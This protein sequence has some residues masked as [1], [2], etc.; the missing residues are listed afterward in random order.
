MLN[1][2]FFYSRV[3]FS[4]DTNQNQTVG[5]IIAG[6][7]SSVAYERLQNI[8][9]GLKAVASRD[10]KSSV[11][12]HIHLKSVLQG[13]V[14][15]A[16]ILPSLK[17]QYK[18]DAISATGVMGRKIQFTITLPKHLLSF[19]SKVSKNCFQ[20]LSLDEC[21]VH[22]FYY[23]R[24]P[25]FSVKGNVI[26]RIP[27]FSVKGNVI[28]LGNVLQGFEGCCEC[29]TF[30]SLL[31]L[32]LLLYLRHCVFFITLLLFLFFVF[33]LSMSFFFLLFDYYCYYFFYHCYF[34]IFHTRSLLQQPWL[35][36]LFPQQLA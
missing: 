22:L 33:F 29:F 24:I 7:K 30:G 1:C 27:Y 5:E 18:T 15:G 36:I 8:A 14:I 19:R 34:F 31:L 32:L 12:R 11:H 26:C 13:I 9:S 20:L 28:F 10:T 17:A 16:S 4:P 2:S 6:A 21:E 25:C 35:T 3:H 23:K